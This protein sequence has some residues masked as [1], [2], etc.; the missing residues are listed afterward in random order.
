MTALT[1]NQAGEE[2]A[3]AIVA[4]HFAAVH[5]TAA[6]FYPPDVL[7]AWSP[8]VTPERVER[9]RQTLLSAEDWTV[10]ARLGGEVVGFGSLAAGRNEIESLYVHPKAG[11]QGVGAALLGALEERA[12]REGPTHLE[13]DAAMNAAPFYVRHGFI[14]L[15]YG[16]HRFQSG[17]GMACA[18]VRK[19]F[20]GESAQ[21]DHP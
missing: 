21:G 1:I 14:V 6:D 18:Y 11:R 17:I 3:E 7:I 5:K 9:M 8:P 12:A 10:V 19:T 13:M 2:D 4:V 15:G 16:T 20:G